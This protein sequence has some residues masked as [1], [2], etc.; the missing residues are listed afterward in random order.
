MNMEGLPGSSSTSDALSADYDVV[1][2]GGV[3]RARACPVDTPG[4]GP[5][6]CRP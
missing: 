6:Y 3:S 4:A 5:M 1:V 2:A